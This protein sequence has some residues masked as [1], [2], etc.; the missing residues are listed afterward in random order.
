METNI[1][2][3]N[4]N[5]NIIEDYIKVSFNP[6]TGDSELNNLK[7]T[8]L[9]QIISKDTSYKNVVQIHISDFYNFIEKYKENSYINWTSLSRRS[10]GWD[11]NIIKTGKKVWNWTWIQLCNLDSHL[12]YDFK[13]IEECK[14]YLDWYLISCDKRIIWDVDRIRQF[15]EKIHF[16]ILDPIWLSSSNLTE[17]EKMYNCG[18]GSSLLG[19]S[20]STR[21]SVA[22]IEEYKHLLDWEILSSNTAFEP[23]IDR[24]IQYID[25]IKPNRLCLN[26]ALDL[27]TL[28]SLKNIYITNCRG[29]FDNWNWNIWGINTTNEYKYKPWYF[30][31]KSAFENANVNW[32]ITAIEQFAEIVFYSEEDNLWNY[33]GEEAPWIGISRNITDKEAILKFQDKIN[34]IALF[35][36]PKCN[37]DTEVVEILVSKHIAFA[38]QQFKGYLPKILESLKIKK[39]TI[40]ALKRFWHRKYRWSCYHRNSDGTEEIVYYFKYWDI[41]KKDWYNNI[42][43]DNELEELMLN[44]PMNY[45][46]SDIIT[47]NKLERQCMILATSKDPWL[48]EHGVFSLEKIFPELDYI[49]LVLKKEENG[50]IHYSRKINVFEHEIEAFENG[51][52]DLPS[53]PW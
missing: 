51:T 35:H 3:Q 27:A 47:N 16:S 18:L 48:K 37:C 49:A 20:A 40:I 38:T 41:F 43:W 11:E 6:L 39:E 7:K 8:I 14:E 28:I 36:N 12:F 45:N 32:T 52:S 46:I 50:I 33:T 30:S 19:I 53:R 26:P 15:Q 22:A 17:N 29:L 42:I 2:S 21:L 23:N 25:Y 24:I 4:D 44:T 5:D 10:K 9:A 1:E 31:W 13:F 34:F